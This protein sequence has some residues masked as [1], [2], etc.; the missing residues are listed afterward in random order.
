MVEAATTA[1]TGMGASVTALG[2][3]A[4]AVVALVAVFVLAKSMLKR[5]H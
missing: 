2:T 3:A 1:I 5:S 4:L